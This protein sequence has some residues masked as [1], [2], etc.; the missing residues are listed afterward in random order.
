MSTAMKRSKSTRTAAGL[1]ALA[2]ALA[3]PRAHAQEEQGPAPAPEKPAQDEGG[4]DDAAR[5]R[6]KE[7][8]EGH[9]QAVA[10]NEA[11]KEMIELFGKVERRLRKVDVLLSD[12]GAGDTSRLSAVGAAGIEELL[13]DSASESRSAIAEIDKILEIA[14][15]L[16]S[17]NPSSSS[18]SGDSGQQQSEQP[19]ESSS[20]LDQ[21]QGST[22]R[23]STPEAPSEQSQQEG[24]QEQQGQGQHQ[25]GEKPG[26]QEQQRGDD[27]R[28]PGASDQTDTRNREGS[29]PPGTGTAR[30]GA[31]VDAGQRWG[32]LPP[33]VR[34][35]FRAESVGDVPPRYRD[36]IDAYYARLNAKSSRRR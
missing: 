33:N 13:R 5:Q 22:R 7:I 6:A 11:Q 29:D 12:A 14:Q 31:G 20:P 19:G 4:E 27:P 9:G 10:G 30:I 26:E 32:D 23:E 2:L 21:S 17:Q 18:S 1:A 16:S 15:E 35:V 8:L 25:Q 36:W 24:E 28:D 3:A 34:D